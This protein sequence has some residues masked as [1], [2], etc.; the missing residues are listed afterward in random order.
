MYKCKK[1]FFN[2]VF[3][4]FSAPCITSN[5]AESGNVMEEVRIYQS[6]NATQLSDVRISLN[7]E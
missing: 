4:F 5:T 3:K 6:A 1:V 2:N 7:Y